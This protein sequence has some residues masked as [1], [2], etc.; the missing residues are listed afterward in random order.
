MQKIKNATLTNLLM[1]ELASI[2]ERLRNIAY[3]SSAASSEDEQ[4]FNDF[5][6]SLLKENQEK[7]RKKMNLSQIKTTKQI[8]RKLKF[9]N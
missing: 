6:I 9:I 3:N 5:M 4:K 2:L 7:I 1:N 8:N